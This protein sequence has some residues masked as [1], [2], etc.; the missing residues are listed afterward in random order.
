M[1]KYLLFFPTLF[2]ACQNAPDPKPNAEKIAWEFTESRNQAIEQMTLLEGG[3]IEL[4]SHKT[5]Y[6]HAD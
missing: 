6:M 1:S 4:R 5:G 2:L 3:K